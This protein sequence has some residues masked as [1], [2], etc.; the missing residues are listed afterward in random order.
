ME[1]ENQQSADDSTLCDFAARGI[2]SRHTPEAYLFCH[3]TNVHTT[4]PVPGII[5]SP[6]TLTLSRVVSNTAPLTATRE[7]DTTP[8][9]AA[10]DM[11]A[12]RLTQY[13]SAIGV[14]LVLYDGLLT[15]KDEVSLIPSCLRVVSG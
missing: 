14:V 9:L 12:G 15:I 2:H 10:L 1:G 11:V 6:L 13:S 3:Y 8:E 5:V 4:P 7:M